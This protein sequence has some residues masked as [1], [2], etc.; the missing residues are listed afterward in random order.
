VGRFVTF[1]FTIGSRRY[2]LHMCSDILR[3]R[4]S[5]QDPGTRLVWPRGGCRERTT[6]VLSEQSV[7]ARMGLVLRIGVVFVVGVWDSGFRVMYVG[8]SKIGKPQ[9]DNWNKLRRERTG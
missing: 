6:Y 7:R 8:I 1:G 2:V 3:I 5:Q 9:Q 4:K